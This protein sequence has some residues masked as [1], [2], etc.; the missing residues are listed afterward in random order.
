MGT[1]FSRNKIR[2]KKDLRNQRRRIPRREW[3]LRHMQDTSRK[4]IT[5]KCQMN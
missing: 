1:E 3:P 4:M 2:I 5:E